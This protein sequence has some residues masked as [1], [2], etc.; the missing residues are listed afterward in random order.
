VPVFLFINLQMIHS[1]PLYDFKVMYNP[2]YMTIAIQNESELQK[3]ACEFIKI[4]QKS[5]NQTSA[6]IVGLSGE[7]GA[8]K[9]A[10]VKAV[11]RGFGI[12]QNVNSPTFVI[13]K[14]YSIA[15]KK[16]QWDTL[17]HIDAYRLD[18]A[19]ELTSLGW[20][21]LVRNSKN[22]IMVEWPEIVESIMPKGSVQI[23][24]CLK[25]DNV[26]EIAISTA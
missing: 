23:N 2:I 22:L 8:G 10:F 20:N 21:T 7:L 16:Y 3:F 11:A 18:S 1:G 24:F 15:D 26:R 13:I 17:V 14:K 25:K 12:I 6:T 9:T 5:G 4:L 19:N